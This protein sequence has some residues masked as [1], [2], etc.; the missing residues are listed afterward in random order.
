MCLDSSARHRL[1]SIPVLAGCWCLK[2]GANARSWLWTLRNFSNFWGSE[3]TF[4][5]YQERAFGTAIYPDLG[6]NIYYPSM[7]LA[8]EAGELLNHVKKLMRDR[9]DLNPVNK[10]HILSELGDVLWYAAAIATECGEKLSEVAKKNLAK[11]EARK[12][13]GTIG[14]SGEER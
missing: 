13:R 8:A 5:E 3:M 4:D 7:G 12:Q 1:T 11:L 6:E 2:G 14:G 9:L 10:Y